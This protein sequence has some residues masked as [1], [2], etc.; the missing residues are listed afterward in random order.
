[1]NEA[2][3]RI[4][5]IRGTKFGAME[6]LRTWLYED[7]IR[8]ILRRPGRADQP[9]EALVPVWPLQMPKILASAA[10]RVARSN[11]TDEVRGNLAGPQ[12]TSIRRFASPLRRGL[13]RLLFGAP[14]WRIGQLLSDPLATGPTSVQELGCDCALEMADPFVLSK[15]GKD[16]L[17]FEAIAENGLG[18]LIAANLADDKVADLSESIL[19]LPHHLSWP[20]VFEWEGET[21]LVPETGS[22]NHVGLWKCQ[23]FPGRWTKVRTLLEG[24]RFHDATLL[25]RDGRWWLFVAVGGEDPGDHS[26]ELRI[27]HSADL[28][29]SPFLSHPQNPIRLSVEGSRPAGK[30]F[31]RDGVVYRP[32]QD[33]RDGY[34][35]GIIIYRIDQLS[36]TNFAE[37]PVSQIEPP[38]GTIGIHTLNQVTENRWIVDIHRTGKM[39]L[40]AC[41]FLAYRLM[42]RS[43]E[44]MT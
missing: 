44:C 9:F 41:P 11:P 35:K 29:R 17:L 1:M 15:D 13:R 4:L 33:G 39:M 10:D 30:I 7:R 6:C 14:K 25:H 2:E 8:A 21:Y 37:T 23:E 42:T 20:F 16:W 12:T 18:K 28:L 34:G 19:D 26:A 32:A 5:S 22:A 24:A 38:S 40:T 36:E 27:Y 43:L 3:M 31:V